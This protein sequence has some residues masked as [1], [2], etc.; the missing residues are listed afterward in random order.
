MAGFYFSYV[1]VFKIRDGRVVYER[2]TIPLRLSVPNEAPNSASTVHPVV[3]AVG[4]PPPLV[5]EFKDGPSSHPSIVGGRDG[6]PF[7]LLETSASLSVDAQ[8]QGKG[9]GVAIGDGKKYGVEKG[10]ERGRCCRRFWKDQE[11]SNDPHS[12]NF[13]FGSHF[14]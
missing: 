7:L 10:S 8:H 13:R 5:I 11:E 4:I 3:G 6:S 14:P 2:R 1:L 9:N 12:R